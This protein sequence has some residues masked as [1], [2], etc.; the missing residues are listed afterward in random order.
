MQILFEYALVDAVWYCWMKYIRFCGC[1]RV[2]SVRP[3]AF[4]VLHIPLPFRRSY[5]SRFGRERTEP[6]RRKAIAERARSAGIGE[7]NVVPF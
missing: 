4:G 5:F 2:T 1:T 3:L 6:K 7:E